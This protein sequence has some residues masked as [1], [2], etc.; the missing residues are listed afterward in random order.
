M[1]AKGEGV[2]NTR[3]LGLFRDFV[4]KVSLEMGTSHL[5]NKTGRQ[6]SITQ[7]SFRLL[8]AN[9]EDALGTKGQR[10]NT[11]NRVY[12][13]VVR[14]GT[15]V[16]VPVVVAID[17]NA[18]ETG[19]E[20]LVHFRKQR[21]QKGARLLR[22]HQLTRVFVVS[23]GSRKEANVAVLNAGLSIDNNRG[24]VKQ[25]GTDGIYTRG[26]QKGVRKL[27]CA[28]ERRLTVFHRNCRVVHN[29]TDGTSEKRYNA[30]EAPRRLV[31]AR[32]AAAA[33]P[34]RR[35]RHTTIGHVRWNITRR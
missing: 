24:V 12:E 10:N 11:G 5:K 30:S 14:M 8:V 20:K 31:A 29:E 32:R 9:T 35:P 4:C 23:F 28:N 33:Y 21:S 34:R 19:A 27:K 13:L 2:S 17:Q 7:N 18:V 22:R 3:Q 1:S 25:L 15:Y 16:V 6:P 26:K